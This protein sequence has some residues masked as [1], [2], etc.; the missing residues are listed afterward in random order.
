[1]LPSRRK[2]T[3]NKHQDQYLY[4]QQINQE[5]RIYQK[6][7]ISVQLEDQ[8]GHCPWN[9]P[10]LFHLHHQ[11]RHLFILKRTLSR[12]GFCNTLSSFW[13]EGISVTI[14]KS[15]SLKV[16]ENLPQ[17]C[18]RHWLIS[19]SSTVGLTRILGKLCVTIVPTSW[20]EWSCIFEST[21]EILPFEDFWANHSR[22]SQNRRLISSLSTVGSTRI[23]DMW[24]V[25]PYYTFG[26][27]E[28]R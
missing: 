24:C 11:A 9:S 10:L 4:E 8:Q 27:V 6:V 21:R 15:N 23:L 12:T 7:R 22:N 18:Q 13:Q 14:W 19:H 5:S 16:S 26:T 25:W 2:K 20:P 17:T 28:M 3:N 1:V